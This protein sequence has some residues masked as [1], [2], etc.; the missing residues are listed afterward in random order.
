MRY[1]MT[2]SAQATVEFGYIADEFAQMGSVE[3]AVFLAELFDALKH[4]CK[5]VHLLNPHQLGAFNV[6]CLV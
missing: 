5:I 2:V 6:S 4:K 1:E 3:Q